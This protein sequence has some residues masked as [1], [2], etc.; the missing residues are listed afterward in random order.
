MNSA[1]VDFI[2]ETVNTVET[3][4]IHSGANSVDISFLDETVNSANVGFLN[5]K[6]T[7]F[8]LSMNTILQKHKEAV[9]GG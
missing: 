7:R 5:I 6:T 9:D 4:F 1:E 8:F 3:D 2:E